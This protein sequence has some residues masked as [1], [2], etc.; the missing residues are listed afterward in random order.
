MPKRNENYVKDPVRKLNQIL[1]ACHWKRI[2]PRLWEKGTCRIFVDAVGIFLYRLQAVRW[3][4]TQGLS[5]SDFQ[6][7]YLAE[8]YIRFIDESRLNLA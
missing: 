5:F 7:K 1:R 4:R 6:P 3:V 8:R 2:R